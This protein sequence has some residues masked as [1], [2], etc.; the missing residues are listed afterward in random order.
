MLSLTL[1]AD[2]FDLFLVFARLG[3]AL[4]LLPGIGEAYVPPQVRLAA[5]LLLTFVVAPVV[6]AE[7][8]PLPGN[9]LSL[10]ALVGG[11]ILVGVFFGVL[12][13]L[14]L[15]A[16]Q[17]SGMIV[18]YQMGLA[19]AF[20]FDPTSAQQGALV[21]GFLSVLG[22]LMVFVTDTH[23]VLLAAVIESYSLF[24]PGG[25]LMIGDMAH[26][27]SDT[28]A[29]SFVVAVQIAAP[30]LIIGLIFYAGLGLLGRLMPQV[31]IFFVA[32]PVQVGMGFVVLAVTAAAMMMWFLTAMTDTFQTF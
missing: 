12:A 15:A 6:A 18:A 5:A 14:I 10:A 13:R 17:M 24:T 7:F 31:Q 28:A 4:M 27:V 2:V 26:V 16:L 21:G 3:G 9:P 32:L 23:H 11:E 30:F 29:R 25:S 19:N 22:V 8:P 20:S 1:P